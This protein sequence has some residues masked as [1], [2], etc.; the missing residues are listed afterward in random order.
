MKLNGT[1]PASQAFRFNGVHNGI[2]AGRACWVVENTL[3]NG[4][5]QGT[6]ANK[7]GTCQRCSFFFQVRKEEGDKYVSTKDLL[8][9][10]DAKTGD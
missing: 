8:N 1:C 3:N 6:F 5:P 10:R 4:Q 7:I 9:K 2:A